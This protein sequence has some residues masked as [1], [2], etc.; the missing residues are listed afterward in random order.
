MAARWSWPLG[1]GLRYSEICMGADEELYET[2][3]SG[4]SRYFTYLYGKIIQETCPS[5]YSADLAIAELVKTRIY[6][7]YIR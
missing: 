4:G 5:R 2:R 6:C 7:I 3:D 1:G